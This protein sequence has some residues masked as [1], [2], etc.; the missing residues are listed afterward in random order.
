MW[1]GPR[2]IG[3]GKGSHVFIL[4]LWFQMWVDVQARGI[5]NGWHWKM[6]KGLKSTNTVN[7]L[8]TDIWWGCML[9]GRCYLQASYNTV[10]TS[11]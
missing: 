4:I 6:V 9:L 8:E 1:G 11:K 7:I 5:E 2:G 10:E 3:N